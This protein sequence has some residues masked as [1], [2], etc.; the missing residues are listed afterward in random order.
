MGVILD[1]KPVYQKVAHKVCF[2]E[3]GRNN[4]TFESTVTTEIDYKTLY[5]LAKPHLASSSIEF[6]IVNSDETTGTIKGVVLVGGFRPVGEF[7]VEP[8][9]FPME[10]KK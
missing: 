8:V 3:L 2:K 7:S 5:R 4:A 9:P 6:T 10:V 1:S